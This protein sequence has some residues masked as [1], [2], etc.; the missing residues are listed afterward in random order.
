MSVASSGV[1]IADSSDSMIAAITESPLP[2]VLCHYVER[3]ALVVAVAVV[4]HVRR[5]SVPD[6][7]A[8][9]M[10]L[11]HV[12]LDRCQSLVQVHP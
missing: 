3:V 6:S 8:V 4:Q 1:A 2:G 5:L 11:C 10:L 12:H 9:I 7:C